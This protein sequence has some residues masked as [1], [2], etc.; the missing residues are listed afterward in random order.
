MSEDEAQTL[1]HKCRLIRPMRLM[2][3]DPETRTM[4]HNPR[5]DLPGGLLVCNPNLVQ[6]GDPEHATGRL[7]PGARLAPI[8]G[9]WREAEPSRMKP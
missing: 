8:E 3:V 1:C 5:C 2:M 6:C 9:K 4:F 7:L